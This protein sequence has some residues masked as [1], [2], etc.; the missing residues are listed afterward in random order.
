MDKIITIQGLSKI[1]DGQSSRSIEALHDINLTVFD[2]EIVCILGPS[3]CG[4]TTLLNIVAGLLSATSGSVRICEEEAFQGNLLVSYIQ[5]SPQLL[6][7]RTVLANAALSLELRNELGSGG[8]S[9]IHS[10]LKFLG[11]EEFSSYYPSELSGGMRQRVALARTLSVK[12]PLI[13]CDE[14]FSSLDFD[15][16]LEIEEF[17]W[18]ANKDERRASIFV[19][20]HI[21]SAISL[22]DRIILMTPRPGRIL[23]V[24]EIDE[25]LRQQ[26]PLKRREFP[27]F[28]RYFSET[29]Q[30]LHNASGV[31]V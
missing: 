29:W 6:P 22:A 21:D 19:T 31:K 28:S 25:S 3:G 13:L 10:L 20:H 26:P 8:L 9:K 5:Q 27:S 7:Y 12:S 23:E 1:Y 4:K 17:F 30:S 2:S 18:K 24:V 11:L 14:P 15:N 16:R